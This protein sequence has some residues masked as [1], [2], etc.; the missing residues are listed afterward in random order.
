MFTDQSSP[1]FYKV[2][3]DLFSERPRG[4]AL[5]QASCYDCPGRAKR[6]FYRGTGHIYIA[7]LW[8]SLAVMLFSGCSSVSK[9]KNPSVK[10]ESARIVKQDQTAKPKYN[11]L[12]DIA[13]RLKGKPYRY[14]G[15]TPKGFD[16]SGF[17]H[18]AYGKAGI[19]IPRTTKAQYRLAQQLSINEAKP[20]D[21]LFFRI[22][23]RKLSHVG[24]YVGNRRFI[25]ASTSKKR[26]AEASLD[27]PYWQKRLLGAGR[28]E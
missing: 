23:S 18:Y 11:N 7:V 19:S 8:M 4:S 20:G 2:T 13:E 26:V 25:H 9:T 14:G 28:I 27:D 16:C 24:L 1:I 3:I 15:V 6:L 5:Y 10:V 12:V 22:N 21:L 17:V